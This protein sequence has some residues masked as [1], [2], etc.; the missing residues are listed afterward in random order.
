MGKFSFKQ[1]HLSMAAVI[2]KKIKPSEVNIEPIRLLQDR[3]PKRCR[4]D[5]LNAIEALEVCRELRDEATLIEAVCKAVALVAESEKDDRFEYLMLN[6]AEDVL[7]KSGKKTTKDYLTAQVHSD[8]IYK[9]CRD[10]EIAW[11][12]LASYFSNIR[13]NARD[14]FYWYR[15]NYELHFVKPNHD[16]NIDKDDKVC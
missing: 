8:P 14:D 15:K 16:G 3:L 11:K 6:E 1:E 10:L 12:T 9:K 5:D 4:V 7:I 2:F 13:E